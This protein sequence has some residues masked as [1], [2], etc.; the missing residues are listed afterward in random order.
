MYM[1]K[2]SYSSKK[3]KDHRTEIDDK[4][5]VASFFMPRQHMPQSQ[6]VPLLKISDYIYSHLRILNLDM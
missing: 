5:V 6:W 1:Y 3:Q 4:R 2:Y